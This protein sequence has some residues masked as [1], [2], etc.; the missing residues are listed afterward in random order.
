MRNA[1]VAKSGLHKGPLE[2]VFLTIGFLQMVFLIIEKQ[3][4][5]KHFVNLKSKYKQE[6]N[7]N[8]KITYI[9]CCFPFLLILIF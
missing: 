7:K 3:Q 4:V 5:Q 9:S 6:E 1:N 8:R 2:N